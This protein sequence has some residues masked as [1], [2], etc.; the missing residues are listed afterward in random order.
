[1]NMGMHKFQIL[2]LLFIMRPRLLI[3]QAIFKSGYYV[4]I[5]IHREP[6]G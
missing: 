1:M 2:I 5:F 3:I 6:W 4:R